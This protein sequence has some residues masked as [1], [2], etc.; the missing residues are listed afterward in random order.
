MDAPTIRPYRAADLEALYEIALRTG[1]AG[2][3]ASKLYRDPRLVGEIW[4]APYAHLTPRTCFILKDEAGVGGY[5]LG[6]L[7]TRDFERQA[8]E[9]WWPSARRGR[10]EPRREERATWSPDDGLRWLIHHPNIVPEAIVGPYPSHLHI[11][12]LPRLQG[13]GF[14]RALLDHWFETVRSLGSKGAHLGVSR[15]NARAIQFYRAYG[16]SELAPQPKG[17]LFFVKPLG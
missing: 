16:L 17:G 6:C 15:A 11:D 12:L 14:G 5:V 9:R 1:D 8:E 10:P 2:Q 4:A 13:R 7:S 3:D